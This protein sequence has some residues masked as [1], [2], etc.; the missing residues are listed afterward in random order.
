MAMTTE[1]E[2][3]TEPAPTKKAGDSKRISLHFVRP[4]LIK[5]DHLLNGRI[6][7]PKDSDIIKMALSIERTGQLQPI[8][9]TKVNGEW[10]AAMGFHR[11]AACRLLAQG[12][13]IEEGDDKRFVHIPDI[14][15]Q[16]KT[17]GT[18]NEEERL[19]MNITENEVRVDTTPTDDAEN[20]RKLMNDFGYSAADCAELYGKSVAWI[21]DTQ[22]ILALSKKARKAI[23]EGKLTMA[24]AK[25]LLKLDPADR[26]SAL[27][28]AADGEGKVSRNMLASAVRE[29]IL[30]DRSPKEVLE[31]DVESDGEQE[32]D[33]A[34]TPK[35][36][37]TA[38]ASSLT[39][40]EI[41]EAFA[42]YAEAE[43]HG[44]L[45]INLLDFMAG[46][47]SQ[48]KLSSFLKKY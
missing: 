42:S 40:K 33:E 17:L 28:E 30:S 8:G 39:L 35:A 16:C 20:I 13:E 15:V 44:E 3:A 48:K 10:N 5:T 9:V 41:K 14:Q 26:E 12:F 23:A 2:Q 22:S 1:E 46:T 31:G 7:P 6:D 36:K 34:P 32:G 24:G 29:A 43:L 25:Q 47:L 4:D 19:V 45:F 11:V 18:M 37:P 38:K 21:S 27:K